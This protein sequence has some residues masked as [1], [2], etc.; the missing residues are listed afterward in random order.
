MRGYKILD[1]NFCCRGLQ[2]RV[3]ETQTHKGPIEPCQSGL[4]FCARALD[5]LSYYGYTPENRYAEVHAVGQIITKEDKSVT[6]ELEI[7]REISFE[8]FAKL[9][10][11]TITTLYNS[12]TK[13]EEYTFRAGVGKCKYKYLR[14]FE[15][16]QLEIENIYTYDQLLM[17]TTWDK[18][19]QMLSKLTYVDSQLDGIQ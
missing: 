10:T 2:Y 15:N 3:G 9:C 1:K 17:S 16:G 5:C 6:D 12:G 13:H 18:Y 7:V 4:H 19:G 11:G 8:E 14:W